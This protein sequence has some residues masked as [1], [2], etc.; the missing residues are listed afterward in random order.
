MKLL[1]VILVVMGVLVMTFVFFSRQDLSSEFERRREALGAPAN[2]EQVLNEADI[3]GLPRPIQR[4]LRTS[5]SV[6]RP[7]VKSVHVTFMAELFSAPGSSAM[8]GLAHQIDFLDPPRRLFF[9]ETRMYG[10][11]VAVLHEYKDS[12]A[13]MRVRMAKLFDVVNISGPDLSKAETVTVLN[14][15][16]A[17]APAALA[18]PQFSWKEL[19]SREAEV[20]FTNGPHSIR[21]VLTIDEEGRLVNFRS[22]DRAELQKDGTLKFLPWTTPL[23]DFKEFNGRTVPGY[24]EAVWHRPEGPFTYGTF[25]VLDVSFNQTELPVKAS[26]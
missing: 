25:K 1:V 21:A 20:T 23:S 19:S 4:H 12:S 14:D 22:D 3:Q 2:S 6:G 11:P 15:I 26:P 13:T 16:S 24:G 10:L 17:F 8:S 9:M 5:G 7:V 18:G